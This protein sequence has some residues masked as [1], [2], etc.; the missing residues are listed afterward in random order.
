MPSTCV[1]FD[2]EFMTP[3]MGKPGHLES[4]T[5]PG[6]RSEPAGVV[7]VRVRSKKS[8]GAVYEALTVT[9]HRRLLMVL[10]SRL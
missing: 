1:G 4:L 3:T 8:F 7:V 6:P 10:P 5:K 9:V 2:S